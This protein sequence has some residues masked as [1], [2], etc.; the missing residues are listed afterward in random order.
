MRG[1]E[2]QPVTAGADGLRVRGGPRHAAP[3]KSLLTKLQIPAGKAM[4]LAAVPTAVFVG[5]GLTPRLALAD[6]NKDIPY[7]PGPCVTR[8]DEPSESASSSP[9]PSASD[10]QK[11]GDSASP[12]P[13]PS[14]SGSAN[15]GDDDKGSE[16]KP[17][18]S[19]SASDSGSDEDKASADKTSAE[20]APSADEDTDKSKVDLDPLGLGG[21]I[22]GLLGGGSKASDDPE[23]S[24][25]ATPKPDPSTSAPS[26]PKPDNPVGDTVGKAGDA[27][28]DTVGGTEKAIRDAAGK[29]GAEVEDLGDDVKGTTP[30]KDDDIPKGADGKERFPCPTADPKALA[31]ATQEE[32]I[33]LLPNDPWTLRSSNL[34]L[35]GLKYEGIKEVR[36][37]D[38][39]LKKVMKFTADSIDIGDLD[40]SV[41][42][43]NG[44]TGHVKAAPGSTSTIRGGKVTL[45]TE[46][47]SGN[48]FGLIPIT[49]SPSFPPPI[50]VPTAIFTNATVTQ[51]GQ[52]GGTLTI[53]GL[54]NYID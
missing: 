39:R 28:G 46:K 27:V 7:A 29:A 36:T 32:G 4:A 5:M 16:P 1:D 48:L 24:A 19:A 30:G 18:S 13:T 37:Y 17:S 52:F 15:G 31:D 9:S 35:T 41:V 49:F 47:L 8:S 2:A 23:P 3:R 40:Q 51:A 43:P 25:S 6:S 14:A 42:Y 38:Q 50:Q 10:G 53:P 45:Y 20:K 11:P 12:G 33:P 22:G 54:H 34:K 26:K 21:L 44:K